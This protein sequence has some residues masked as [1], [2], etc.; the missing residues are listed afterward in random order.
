MKIAIRYTMKFLITLI[1]SL[2]FIQVFAQSLSESTTEIKS[3]V[4]EE[5]IVT[6]QKREES[7]QDVPISI[8][9]F[10]GESIRSSGVSKLETLAETVPNFFVSESFVGDAMFV[11]GI[12]SAQ[13]NLGTEMAVGQV[14]DG[15]FYGRSRFSRLAFMDVAMVEVLKGPQGALIGKNTTAG[16]IIITTAQPTDTF[17][18]WLTPSYEILAE[19]GFTIEGAVSGPFTD[20]L[21]A[22]LAIR[23][24]ERDGYFDNTETGEEQVSNESIFIRGKLLWEPT[25][26]I[27]MTLTYQYGDM[28]FDGENNQISLCDFT[29]P[30]LP[31]PGG[32]I[33]LTSVLTAGTMEDCTANFDLHS[34]APRRGE[35]N[36]SGKDTDFNTVSLVANWQVG[37]L[38]ITS[39]TGWAE[40]DYVDIMDSDR[41][42]AESLSVEFQENYEQLSQELRLISPQGRT[43][44]YIA[45]FYLQDKEQHTKFGIDVVAFNARRNTLTDEDGTTYAAFG[46]LTWN[47]NDQWSA[48]IGGRFTHEEKEARSQGFPSLLYDT[49]TPTVVPPFAPAGLPRIHDVTDD[50]TEDNFSPT[51]NLQWRPNDDMMFYGSVRRGF[52]AGAFNHALVATQANALAKFKVD[53]EDVTAFEIGTKMRLLHGAA[54]LNMNYFYSDFSDLQVATLRGNDIINDVVNA[55]DS[56]SQGFE[57]D[58]TWRPIENLTLF[59]AIGYLDS[60]FDKFPNATCYALQS[61]TECVAGQ[62][63]LKGQPFQFAPDLTATVNAEYVWHLSNGYQLIGFLQAYYTDEYFLT[64]DLDPK[65]VQDDYIK[66]DGRLTL[67]APQDKW[68]IS[69][70][71]RNIGDQISS[72]VGDDVPIQTGTVWR[73]VEPPRSLTI[74][75]T[76]R[77]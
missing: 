46:Q 53:S 7:L 31:T 70:I 3:R 20:Q 67:A 43:F 19:D 33:N 74:Q 50:F 27:D 72:N 58:L 49:D 5:I 65:L 26:N 11:R 51:F 42:V 52:K 12:G 48:T 4:L 45:G 66:Y 8:S 71:S 13:N 38:T 77:F 1:L 40:Y 55:A 59:T 22:R 23:Y 17:E 16:A 21:K 41:T 2:A 57:L 56:T 35:G 18:A 25:K 34:A 54:Q 44:D 32:L 28:E 75:G 30:Q 73:S 47:I 68:E 15:V 69:L 6:A 39:I 64:Q 63:D 24:D 62:Q 76:W 36:F 61:P 10:T 9:A 29:T 37:D 14:I 60:E